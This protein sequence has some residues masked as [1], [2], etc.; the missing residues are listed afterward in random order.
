MNLPQDSYGSNLHLLLQKKQLFNEILICSQIL[1][2][3]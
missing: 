3:M 1:V 2:Y